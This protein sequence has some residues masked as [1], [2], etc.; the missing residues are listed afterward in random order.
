M[1]LQRDIGTTKFRKSYIDFI[2]KGSEDRR[3][4]ILSG[5]ELL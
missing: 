2:F 1:R 3:R 5:G 4:R